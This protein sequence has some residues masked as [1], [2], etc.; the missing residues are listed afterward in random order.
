[1]GVQRVGHYWPTEQ[2]YSSHLSFLKRIANLGYLDIYI[3]IYLAPA[4]LSAQLLIGAC[5]WDNQL[6]FVCPENCH[7]HSP[8]L[9]HRMVMVLLFKDLIFMILVIAC[10]TWTAIYFS[11]LNGKKMRKCPSHCRQFPPVISSVCWK[12]VKCSFSYWFIQ[13]NQDK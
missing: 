6:S 9:L 10:S 4:H 12:L 1:M 13:T 2:Q 7:S 3:Y 8:I 11:T 5:P